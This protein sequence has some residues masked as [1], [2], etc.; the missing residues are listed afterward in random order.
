VL[1]VS[2]GPVALAP[3]ALVTVRPS[4]VVSAVTTL[5]A[6]AGPLLVTVTVSVTLAPS[7]ACAGTLSMA[8]RS[9]LSGT[10]WVTVGVSAVEG[11]PA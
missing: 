10:T 7:A 2:T 1:Q 8:F 3:S 5:M 11:E 4:A 9:A 6:V